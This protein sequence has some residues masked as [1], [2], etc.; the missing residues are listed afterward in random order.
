VSAMPVREE[1]SR[2]VEM[3]RRKRANL[4]PA[5]RYRPNVAA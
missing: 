5:H 2:R 1:R 3:L 4:G